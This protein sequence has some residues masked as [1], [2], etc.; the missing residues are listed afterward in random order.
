[1]YDIVLHA[2]FKARSELKGYKIR[3]KYIN[4]IKH[5]PN[6][7]NVFAIIT[8]TDG[9]SSH[10][11]VSEYILIMNEELEKY[12]CRVHFSD[13]GDGKYELSFIYR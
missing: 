12:N 9:G 13:I 8:E 11:I 2:S 1:M 7:Y 4:D 10:A 5:S 3:I 6:L